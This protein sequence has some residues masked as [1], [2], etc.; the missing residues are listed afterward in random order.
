MS[1]GGIV[2]GC[3]SSNIL[4]LLEDSGVGRSDERDFL[5]HTCTPRCGH[6]P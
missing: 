3:S 5:T 1:V 2:S 4:I 6:S